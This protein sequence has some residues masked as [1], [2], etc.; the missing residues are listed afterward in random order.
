MSFGF[1]NLRQGALVCLPPS[2]FAKSVVDLADCFPGRTFENVLGKQLAVRDLEEKLN[3]ADRGQLARSLVLSP[4]A[5]LYG[6]LRQLVN[7]N[8]M[9][10]S[11]MDKLFDFVCIAAAYWYSFAKTRSTK[12]QLS[13]R[14]QIYVMTTLLAAG[15]IVASRNFI[16]KYLDRVFEAGILKLNLVTLNRRFLRVNVLSVKV[17]L[18][19]IAFQILTY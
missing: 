15:A 2:Y 7:T 16:Q 9:I 18:W 17:N 13:Q 8:N 14:R 3:E 10:M 1:S 4:D 11:N 12:M 6:V 5:K 19:V